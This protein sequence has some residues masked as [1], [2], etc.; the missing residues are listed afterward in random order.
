MPPTEQP[1]KATLEKLWPLAIAAAGLVAVVNFLVALLIAI[2]GDV[3]HPALAESQ[4][5]VLFVV[6]GVAMAVQ[7]VLM[8]VM[9]R[10]LWVRQQEG[11]LPQAR[12]RGGLRLPVTAALA[13]PAVR[14]RL[15]VVRHAGRRRRSGASAFVRV[16]RSVVM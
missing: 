5:W 4:A 2:F 11:E 13:H 9:H 3:L 10:Q 16:G 8:A 14:R 6:A 1:S 15:R 7:A 12:W